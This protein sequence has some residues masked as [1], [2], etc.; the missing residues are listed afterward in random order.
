MKK[1]LLSYFICLISISANAKVL[2][3]EKSLYRNILV[4]EISNRRCM[5]FGRRSR[6]PDYRSCIY[7]T[8]PDYLVFSYTKLVL[9]GLSIVPNPKSILIIGLGGG[10]LPISLEKLYPQTK[11][12]SVEIDDAVVRVAKQWFNYQESD[13]QKVH[14]VDG[15]VYVKRQIRNQQKYDLIILDAFNGDYIPEHLMT[16]EFLQETKQLL[17]TNGLL[18]A[19]T[20]SN[21]KLYHHES[22]TYQKV[23][24]AYNYVHSQK[25]GNRVIYANVSD[26]TIEN[27]DLKMHPQLADQL[28]DM[29]VNINRFKKLVTNKPDWKEEV[30]PLT[31]QYSPAN[32]LK[33]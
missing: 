24:G 16:K 17:S 25:S 4:E 20:F 2:H 33:Q 8:K 13:K 19:N 30:R 26:K 1:L 31:D 14:I 29:G 5:V 23:F 6:H 15:R 27:A 11:I 7:R 28:S 12:D 32:L 21:N 3:A 18:I 22:V 9:A 10:T